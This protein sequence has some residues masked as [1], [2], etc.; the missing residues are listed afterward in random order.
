MNKRLISILQYTVFLGAGIFLV[1]WQLKGMTAE[2]KSQFTSA[3]RS[4]NYW[5]IIPIVFMSLFSHLSRAYRWKLLLE[6]LEYYPKIKNVFAVT[7]VGY[8][9]NAAIPRLGEILKCTF[10]AKYENL[11]ESKKPIAMASS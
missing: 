2:Q 6:P 5:L 7:M 1:W 11:S 8:L 3:L 10:L 9:A 4:A